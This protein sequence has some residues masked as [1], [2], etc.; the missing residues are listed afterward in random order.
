MEATAQATPQQAQAKATLDAQRAR[1]RRKEKTEP[2]SG[3]DLKLAAVVKNAREEAV[4]RSL[5]LTVAGTSFALVGALVAW[6]ILSARTLGDMF[7]NTRLGAIRFTAK[8]VFEMLP[9]F[10][11]M[12]PFTFTPTI[13]AIAAGTM[14]AM[15]GLAVTLIF[16][17]SFIPIY[18][19]INPI[20]AIRIFGIS[21]IRMFF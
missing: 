21:I 14:T 10:Q 3:A 9:N 19:L 18:I 12:Q 1:D 2:M 5:D 13:G 15:V 6:L 11:K 16:L 17:A 8:S 20:D 7:K 4:R